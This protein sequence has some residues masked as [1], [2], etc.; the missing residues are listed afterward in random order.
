M[1]F[2]LKL[3]QCCDNNS[4]RPTMEHIVFKNNKIVASNA[5]ILIAVDFDDIPF[6][7][8]DISILE[9]KSIH[10]KGFSKIWNKDVKITEEG[11]MCESEYILVPWS[12]EV[13]KYPQWEKI[14]PD[15]KKIKPVKSIGINSVLL[16]KL[17]HSFPC[18]PSRRG[19]FE[20]YFNEANGAIVVFNQPHV[21]KTFAIIMPLMQTEKFNP[22][23]NR[24][25][26]RFN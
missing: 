10:Q 26:M 20:L 1:K 5:H 18:E 4:L 2:N 11:L 16:N 24:E 8:K 7:E 15:L 19:Q 9:G 25:T 21:F 12:K 6:S 14:I 23:L 22:V 17:A 3:H 13:F